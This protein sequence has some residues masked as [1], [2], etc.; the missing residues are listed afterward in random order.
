MNQ[1]ANLVNIYNGEV[2]MSSREISDLTGKR[3]DNVMADI[4]K[5]LIEIQSPEKLGDYTDTKN[6]TQQMLLLNKEECLCLISGY[7][8]KLRMA[9]I[10]RWQELESQKPLIPQ[11][12]PEALRL[13]ADLAEQKQIVEQQLAIAAPKAEFVDRYVQATGSLGFREVCK[14]LKVKENFFRNFLLA[15]R[16]MYPL[17]GKLAPY[18]EHLDCN[19]FEVKTGE[20]PHNGHAYTQIKFTPKG[21]QWIA[22]LLAREQL[23]AA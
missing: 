21:I 17:A 9:I 11:T 4:R 7:S 22:G 10:K 6:R 19:R 3:H 16:I 12:L 18:S 5:M 20:N 23:E 2:T 1:I 14:L 15:K 13:A 8:I